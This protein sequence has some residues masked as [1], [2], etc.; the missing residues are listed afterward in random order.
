MIDLHNV[1]IWSQRQIDELKN[2]YTILSKGS[3]RFLKYGNFTCKFLHY[4]KISDNEDLHLIFVT[5]GVPQSKMNNPE[6]EYIHTYFQSP[7]LLDS[8]RLFLEL[9]DNLLASEV[10]FKMQLRRLPASTR[11]YIV[12]AKPSPLNLCNEIPLPS[13]TISEIL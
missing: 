2:G 8:R 4:K 1:K 7:T 3:T 11:N 13:F 12:S 9:T 10:H 6:Y 5:E